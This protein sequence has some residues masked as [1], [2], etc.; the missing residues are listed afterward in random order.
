MRRALLVSVLAITLA[1]PGAAQARS[2][3]CS[4]SGDYCTSATARGGGALLRLATFSFRGLVRVCVE[5]PSG[6]GTC[7]RFPLR[8][9]KEG[10]FV[11]FVRWGVHFPDRGAGTYRVRW[12]KFGGTLGPPLT[13]KR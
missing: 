11:S 5:P 2:S 1:L 3:Y 6:A 10:I 7:K 13:F 9:S 4:P 8:K 12:Q